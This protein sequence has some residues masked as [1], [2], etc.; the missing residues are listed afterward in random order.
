MSVPPQ[1]P[2]PY[3]EQ[4]DH[5]GRPPGQSGWQP[6]PGQQPGGY[7]PPAQGFPQGGQQ[8]GYGP[9]P[10]GYP[11]HPGQGQPAGQPGYGLPPHGLPP[12]GL[13]P[14]GQPDQFHQPGYG[15]PGG[16]GGPYGAPP[17]RNP[18]PWILAGA[19]VL[20]IGVVAVLVFTLGGGG[21][22]GTAEAVV[23]E[24]NKGADADIDNIRGLTCKKD[25]G[26]LDRLKESL[27]PAAGAADVPEEFKDIK[28][29]FTLGE[30]TESG[31]TAQAK[32]TVAYTGVPEELKEFLKDKS[33]TLKMVKEEGDW[34]V[35]DSFGANF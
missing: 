28:A 2:G 22:K 1:Q 25:L 4:P 34:K 5:L 13:Q 21:A 15:Q 17:R 33:D 26:E 16:F 29:K 24:M 11:Q 32:I 30:V 3:G 14:Y 9:P 35:C 8:P 10:G 6:G 19:G 31:D 12:H 20:V 18:L 27:D 7:P 23:A